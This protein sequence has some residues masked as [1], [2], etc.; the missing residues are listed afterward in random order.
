MF[1]L[2]LVLALAVSIP[3]ILCWYPDLDEFEN[4]QGH[5]CIQC[6]T[7][8]VGRGIRYPIKLCNH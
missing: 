8:S 7:A 4:R 6:D 2:H 3:S 1:P 5:D